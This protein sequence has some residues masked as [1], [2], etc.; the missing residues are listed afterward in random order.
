M[1]EMDFALKGG[2]RMTKEN[3]N[4]SF[5]VTFSPPFSLTLFLC[6]LNTK[7]TFL[8]MLCVICKNSASVLLLTFDFCSEPDKHAGLDLGVDSAPSSSTCS[9]N[10]SRRHVNIL[11]LLCGALL[12]M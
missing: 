5:I 4:D 11:Y 7:M 12:S 6:T 10:G 8:F 2:P 3:F 1:T 9:G